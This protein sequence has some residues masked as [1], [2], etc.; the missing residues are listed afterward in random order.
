M[1]R[2]MTI[3]TRVLAV[4]G[5]LAVG[6]GLVFLYL[7]ATMTNLLFEVLAIVIALMLAAAAFLIAAF[8]DWFAAFDGGIKKHVHRFI[9]YLLG[10]LA[11][12]LTGVFLGYYPEVTMPLL[13][14]F[15]AVH[16]LA[17]GVSGLLLARK[18]KH[19]KLEHRAMYLFGVLSVLFSAT[20]AA[21]YRTLDNASAT[22]VLG[23]YLCFV[24]AKLLFA[25]WD[26]HHAAKPAKQSYLRST[27]SMNPSL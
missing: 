26:V 22:A 9:F 21:L 27:G 17:F 24:G 13:V 1:L 2:E 12:A 7:H 20:M 11:F 19:H 6:L 15:A 5:S 10:G 18:A 16:A 23:A 8:T 3:R 25:A 4:H 14:A